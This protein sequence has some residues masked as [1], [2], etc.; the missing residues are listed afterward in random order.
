M[1]RRS[2]A[3]PCRASTL[4]AMELEKSCKVGKVWSGLDGH[5]A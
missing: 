1:D 2:L 4:G 3:A 5:N